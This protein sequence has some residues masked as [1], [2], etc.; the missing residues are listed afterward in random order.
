M[1]I[2]CSPA[3]AKAMAGCPPYYPGEIRRSCFVSFWRVILF[4]PHLFKA[5]NLIFSEGGQNSAP[6]AA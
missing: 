5:I 3:V 1:V 4:I 2:N 6:S